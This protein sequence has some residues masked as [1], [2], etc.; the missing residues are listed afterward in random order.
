[1]Q[2]YYL[3]ER[4]EQCEAIIDGSQAHRYNSPFPNVGY[5]IHVNA[6][7]RFLKENEIPFFER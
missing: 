5:C 2:A 4:M 6:I 3:G 7:K 1:M